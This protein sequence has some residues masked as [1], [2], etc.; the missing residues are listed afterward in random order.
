[1]KLLVILRKKLIGQR[2]VYYTGPF[3]R[4]VLNLAKIL[5]VCKLQER[6]GSTM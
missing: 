6:T 3:T 5:E 1:M 2:S 4:K